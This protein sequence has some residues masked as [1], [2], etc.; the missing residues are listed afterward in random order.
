[1]LFHYCRMIS[2]IFKF[3]YIRINR[4]RQLNTAASRNQFE[5]HCVKWCSNLSMDGSRILN[6]S[7]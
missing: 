2:F 7:R 1:M 6:S 5:N 4:Y 3:F